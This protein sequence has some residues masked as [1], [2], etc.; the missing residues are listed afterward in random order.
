MVLFPAGNVSGPTEIVAPA[1]VFEVLF[2]VEILFT[3]LFGVSVITSDSSLIPGVVTCF[4]ADPLLGPGT[5]P[6]I[7][8]PP[9]NSSIAVLIDGVLFAFQKVVSARD[10]S[11]DPFA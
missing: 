8:A 1:A 9:P 3:L 7:I 2:A 4:E 10:V 5:L 11:P 6:A